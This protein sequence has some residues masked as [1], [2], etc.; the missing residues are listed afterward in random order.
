MFSKYIYI[1]SLKN[2]KN[3]FIFFQIIVLL[4]MSLLKVFISQE[5]YFTSELYGMLKKTEILIHIDSMHFILYISTYIDHYVEKVLYLH[6]K[7]QNCSL[8]KYC[9]LWYSWLPMHIIKSTHQDCHIHSFF[10]Q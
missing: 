9:L 2:K 8:K 4:T 1:F 7:T 5:Y 3:I 10:Y 6:S